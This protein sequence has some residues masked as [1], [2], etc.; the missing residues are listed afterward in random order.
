[1]TTKLLDII[2]YHVSKLRIASLHSIVNVTIVWPWY[3][4]C[5]TQ[6]RVRISFKASLIMSETIQ[7]SHLSW[8]GDCAV[9]YLKKSPASYCAGP[10]SVSGPLLRGLW[11]TELHGAGFSPVTIP[12]TLMQYAYLWPAVLQKYLRITAVVWTTSFIQTVKNIKEYK[13]TLSRIQN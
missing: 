11:W 6:S 3:F 13:T 7:L 5:W 9:P 12:T 10:G 1:M 2:T 8:N 4:Q